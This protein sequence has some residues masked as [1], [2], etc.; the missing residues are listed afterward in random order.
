MAHATDFFPGTDTV[1]ASFLVSGDPFNGPV[2]ASYGRSGLADG[3]FTDRF[4]FALGQAGLGSG[5]ITTNFSGAAGN[6]TDLD[7]LPDEVTFN[8]GAVTFN[9]P[10]VHIGNQETGGLSDIAITPGVLNVL[11]ITYRSR[12]DG[13]FGGTLNFTPTALEVVP[14]PTT[15][16][17][18]MVGFAG[19]GAMMRRRKP[20]PAIRFAF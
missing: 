10:I 8:N 12:G 15:W 19:V 1:D 14:E 5:S 4:L 6:S 20:R 2:S 18:L 7:F 3:T 16:A 9:V 11:S 17:L 13:S